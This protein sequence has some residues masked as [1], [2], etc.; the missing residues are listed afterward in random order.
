MGCV[1][2]LTRRQRDMAQRVLI[3]G[4]TGFV[5]SAVARAFLATGY[6][7][8]ALMR[9]GSDR[10]NLAELSVEAALGDLTDAAAVRAALEDCDGLVHVAADY[11]FFVPD[12]AALYAVNVD[13]TSTLMRAALELGVK[14]VVHT[15]SVA[16]LGHRDDG[17]PADEGTVGVLEEMVG[18]YKRSKFMAEQVVSCLVAD[19]GLPAVIVNPSAPVG[20]RDARPTPTGRMVLEAA[21]GRMPAYLDTGLN[22][23]HVDDVGSGHVLAY[24]RGRVGER[25][26]LGGDNLPLAEIFSRIARLTGRRAPRLRLAP[27]PLIPLAWLAEAWARITAT[28]P[29]LTRDELAMARHTMYFTSAKAER[30]LEYTHRP[31]DAAFADAVGWFAR[32]GLVVPRREIETR[33]ARAAAE[34]VER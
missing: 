20:P 32:R 1:Q 5:G 26:I 24:E 28:A 9:A 27:G 21:R 17:A 22:V 23:V 8:R 6:R 15:S 3:T 4:A 30:E 33:E 2:T 34:K 7:V 12:P 14:R 19:A 31:A 16:V 11:R 10:S 13:G 18:H 29:R 25:Y